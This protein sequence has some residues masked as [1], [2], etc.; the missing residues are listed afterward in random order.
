[1]Y[2]TNLSDSVVDGICKVASNDFLEARRFS[3]E[4]FSFSVLLQFPSFSGSTQVSDFFLISFSLDES[5]PGPLFFRLIP[6]LALGLNSVP[7]GIPEP[8]L[9]RLGK[10]GLG[11]RGKFPDP[12]ALVVAV[13]EHCSSSGSDSQISVVRELDGPATG[14]DGRTSG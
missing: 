4:D 12:L 14:V 8:L 5:D 2:T 13:F 9:F 1:M 6:N 3:K 11:G 10:T 7:L